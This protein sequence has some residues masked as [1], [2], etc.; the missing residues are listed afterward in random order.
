MRWLMWFA[1]GFTMAC[2]A[3]V[4][5]LFGWWLL[6]I[7]ACCAVALGVLCFIRTP[8]SKR[9]A[10]VLLG[11]IVSFLWLW[12]FD[13]FYLLPV[14]QLDGQTQIMQIRVTDYSRQLK[15]G[16]AVEGKTEIDGKTYIEGRI[17]CSFD[18][19]TPYSSQKYTKQEK[20]KDLLLIFVVLLFIWWLLLI[21][22]VIYT[23]ESIWNRIK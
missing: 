7:A 18:D 20:I 4:Y 6:L 15:S 9:L 12:C 8:F 5:L 10:Y 19:G 16:V 23:V 17:Y 11:C 1:V 21:F 2:A 3:G 13:R 22:A 14:R